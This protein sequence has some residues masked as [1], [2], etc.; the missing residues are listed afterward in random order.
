MNQEA[1]RFHLFSKISLKQKVKWWYKNG[2]SKGKIS[3]ESKPR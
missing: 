2:E 3:D 1:M